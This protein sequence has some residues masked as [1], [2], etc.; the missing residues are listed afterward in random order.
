MHAS[1]LIPEAITRHLSMIRRY[2]RPTEQFRSAALAMAVLAL[3]GASTSQ[4][5]AQVGTATLSGVV[6]DA[7]GA[8]IPNANVELQSQSEKMARQTVTNASGAY[9]I[10]A[11]PPGTYTLQV[12]SQ[13]FGEEVQ[14]DIPLSSGQASSLNV[15]LGLAKLTQDV[16]VTE[17]PPLLETATATVGSVLQTQQINNL[18]ILGRNFTSLLVTSGG[19]A[20]VNAPDGGNNLAV[21]GTGVN[22]SVFG[23]RQRDNDFS[24]DGVSN[25][26]PLFSSIP[27]FPPPEAIA[28]MKLSSGMSS[29]AY[30]HASGANINLVTKSG[31]EKLH[32]DGWEF[33]R[34]NVL[35]ARPY[36]S[37]SVTP[38]RYNQFG[39]AVGGPLVLPKILSA[40]KRWYFFAYYEGIRIRQNTNVVALVPTAAELA[41]NFSG[42]PVIYNPYSTTTLPDGTQTRTPFPNNQIPPDLL[43]QSALT[44][45]KAL[46]PAPNLAPGV[47]P[48]SNYLAGLPSPTNGNQWSGRI[49][50]QFGSRDYFF[51]RYSQANNPSETYALP[52]LPS[53]SY[54]RY[55]NIA[56]SDTHTFTP[57]FVVT[58]RFGLERINDGTDTLGDHSLATQAGTIDAFP[59]WHGIDQIPPILITN[60][61]GLSQSNGF[62]GPQYFIE[63]MGDASKTLGRHTIQFGGAI[64]RTSFKTDNAT[65]TQENFVS[66]QTSNF[67]SGTGDALAS[68]LL[69]TPDA[70]G[71]VVGSTEGNM[72]GYAYASYVQDDWRLNPK[73]TLNLGFRYDYAHPLVNQLGSGTFIFATGQYVW[74]KRNPITGA[75]PNIRAGLIPPDHNNFQPRVGVAYGV[76]DRTVFRASYGIFA[77]V[78]GPNYAQTQQGNRG[79]WPFSFPQTVSGLNSGVPNAFLA[80]PF[81]GPAEGSATPLGCEQCLDAYGPESRTPYVQE[82]TASMQRTLSPSMMFELTYF[83]A[84]GIKLG[85]Q[86]VDNTA[87][88]PGPGP[89]TAR[90]VYPDFPVFVDNGFN[91]FASHYN[92]L[93]V[94]FEKRYS[95][96]LTLAAN[97]TWSKNI[98]Y[99][100]SLVNEGY[101]FASPTRFNVA[102]QKGPAGF[103]LPQ[104]FVVSYVYEL[105]VKLKN[106]PANAVLGGWSVAGITQLDNGLPFATLLS[107]DNE[108]IGSISGRLPEF[109]NFTAGANPAL[110]KRTINQWF[111]TTAFPVPAP[112]TVGNAPRNL[113]RGQGL[114]T[115]DFSFYK[116]FD[117]GERARF[118][119]RGEFYNLFNETTFGTPNDLADTPQFGTVSSTRLSGRTTQ[120]AAKVHW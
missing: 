42:D 37:P 50:H 48:G 44:I 115:S 7:S 111:N 4:V 101:P 91:R 114:R 49:D 35:D 53:A 109:S 107:T 10:P 25:N 69:G 68:Y 66:T 98:D 72:L 8:V 1:F 26:E 82:W 96:G 12:K 33:L 29:G 97:Y 119:L 77:D 103:D 64:M 17:A 73:L 31:S 92:A 84:H 88:V 54:A 76:N 22:P 20:P 78:F 55:T 38:Y 30:G 113:A 74:D 120:V 104:R 67:A 57:T 28:E 116:Q 100:D 63:E 99:V 32:A 59:A 93:N 75:A 41:G 5:R 18:P 34:N 110:A 11:I 81:P 79:D 23:Q 52:A 95:K 90:Q 13:G 105:P 106:K 6:T 36:F 83:G 62:Y 80:N 61:P 43:N 112:Y 39:A 24:L 3:Y 94:K 2:F 86:I 15:A 58:G 85:S 45:A 108:N 27:I 71:R 21:G 56:V 102:Q 70:A 14:R 47:I 87:T 19:V 118:E 40:E 60:Y 9:V 117:L 89:I 65:G 16:T 46:Y 51:V